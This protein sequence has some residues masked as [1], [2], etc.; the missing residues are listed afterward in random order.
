MIA[1][2]RGLDISIGV[3]W[4]FSKGDPPCAATTEVIE[5]GIPSLAATPGVAGSSTPPG[6]VSKTPHSP[7][8][9]STIAD[10]LVNSMPS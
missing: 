8:D 9:K 5:I 10:P 7:T 1:I 4:S 3:S 6:A 2:T